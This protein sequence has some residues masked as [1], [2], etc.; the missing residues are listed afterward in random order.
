[1]A[2]PRPMNR[3]RC[4]AKALPTRRQRAASVAQ[5]ASTLLRS[6]WRRR[7]SR[8][9]SPASTRE[10]I[11]VGRRPGEGRLV[12]LQGVA[13]RIPQ[14]AERTVRRVDDLL[15]AYAGCVEPPDRQV[16]VV[17]DELR[18]DAALAVVLRL[19]RSGSA[20]DQREARALRRVEPDEGSGAVEESQADDVA[21]E[22]ELGFRVLDED[23]RTADLADVPER[24]D[25]RHSSSPRPAGVT[26]DGSTQP[27]SRRTTGNRSSSTTTANP[28]ATQNGGDAALVASGRAPRSGYASTA[29]K[30]R[31]SRSVQTA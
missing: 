28:A 1:M 31:P 15:V 10:P 21:V 13:F 16:Q 11:R 30:P 17:D 23:E 22:H 8:P 14:E 3:M 20:R 12:E 6:R 5:S 4:S 2:T 19:G 26:S 24:L 9:G 25:H 7:G 29:A 27:S 18:N